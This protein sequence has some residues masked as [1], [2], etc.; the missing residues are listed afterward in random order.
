MYKFNPGPSNYLFELVSGKYTII[1]LEVTSWKNSLKYNWSRDG[2]FPEIVQAGILSFCYDDKPREIK[3]L[4][5]LE[6][7]CTP[8]INS[9]LSEYFTKLTGITNEYI[10]KNS[11]SF[12]KIIEIITKLSYESTIISNGNDVEIINQNLKLYEI[13]SK[14]IC[15]VS[16]RLFFS[17]KFNIPYKDCISSKLPSLIGL[18]KHNPKHAHNALFDCESILTVLAAAIS[19]KIIN[20]EN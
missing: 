10:Q 3:I 2:E 14:G 15:G 8:K 19:A 5:K 1:D 18:T 17:R 12:E 13:K 16:V 7:V 6:F 4:N 11:V 20:D 9:N